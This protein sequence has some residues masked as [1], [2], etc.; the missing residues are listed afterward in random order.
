MCVAVALQT[1]KI[2]CWISMCLFTVA[3]SFCRVN[4][5]NCFTVRRQQIPDVTNH[6][7][8]RF[9]SEPSA[10]KEL[11][12]HYLAALAFS[13]YAQRAGDKAFFDS[14]V[15]RCN[16]LGKLHACDFDNINTAISAAGLTMP[17]SVQKIP[18]EP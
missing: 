15:A 1:G 12:G 9:L 18:D 5:V 4:V 16:E 2:L 13:F 14:V 10:W 6:I 17:S 3:H 8:N 7:K 11:D